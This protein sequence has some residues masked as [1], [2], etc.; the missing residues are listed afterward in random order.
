M[1]S[2]LPIAY[3]ELLVESET[4]HVTRLAPVTRGMQPSL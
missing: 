2:L 1:A 3:S 4:Q